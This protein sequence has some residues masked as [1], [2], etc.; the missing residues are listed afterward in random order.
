MEAVMHS[1]DAVAIIGMS[2]R[3]PGAAD[4]I[5]F[6][7]NLCT[8]TESIHFPSIEECVASGV[9]RSEVTKSNYVRAKG[10]L[11]TAGM[12]DA[13]FFRMPPSQ[14]RMMDPQHRLL[15]EC[16]WEAFE[17]AGYNPRECT[18]A[19]GVF[20]GCTTG[21]S[22][23]NRYVKPESQGKL[24]DYQNN[25]HNGTDFLATWVS[26]LLNL[27][28]P[29]MA[30]QTA[31]STGLVAVVTAV[32]SLLSHQ[33]DIA[34]AGAVSVDY[35]L[36]A[37]H[38]H[39][40]G[41]IL[42]SDGRCRPFDSRADGTVRGNGVGTVL[43]KRLED[44]M[45]DHDHIYAI[46]R[47]AAA[48]NDGFLKM[49][50]TAPSI[51]GQAAVITKALE[52]ASLDPDSVG[53]VEAHGTATPLG[54]PIEVA[55]LNKA[56]RSVSTKKSCALGSVK[57]NIGHLDAA[58]GIAGL[59]KAV[60]SVHHGKIPPTVHFQ[61]P[62]PLLRLEEGPFFV[63]TM[64]REWPE[65]RRAGV[66]SFGMGG[67]NAHVV[68]EQA[69]PPPARLGSPADKRVILPLSA[70]TPAALG[71]MSQRLSEHLERHPELPLG[72]VAHTLQ[73]GRETF[74]YRGLLAQH[75]P[76]SAWQL[77]A[78]GDTPVQE[79][80]VMFLFPGQGAQHVGMGRAFYTSEPGFSRALDTCAQILQGEL[81]TD[82][83]DLLY[84]DSAPGQALEQTRL[85]Q[86]VL[87]AVEYALAQLWLSKGI[88]PVAMLGHSLGEY[89]AACLAGVFS[90][91]DALK[92][93]S[94]RGALMQQ[95]AAG[96]MLAVTFPAEEAAARLPKG[97]VVC[98]A[99]SPQSC[100]VGGDAAAVLRLQRQFEIENIACRLLRTSH[101]FHS[102]LM[103]PVL[104]PLA[105]VFNSIS[106]QPPTIPYLSN[107]TGDWVTREQATN[108]DYWLSHVTCPVQFSP[109]L[110][111]AVRD[112]EPI[113]LEVGPGRTLT[114]L[115]AQQ[116]AHPH[117][118]FS[119]LPSDAEGDSTVLQETIHRL[120]FHGAAVSRPVS[121]TSTRRVSLPTYPFQR[122]HFWAGNHACADEP[123]EPTSISELP[124]SSS[125]ASVS[126]SASDAGQALENVIM[127]IWEETLGLS[128]INPHDDFF[129]LGG[130]SLQ[131]V[132]VANRIKSKIS[133][134][135]ST[136][137]L[138]QAPTISA[139]AQIL[140]ASP[141][142]QRSESAL[143]PLKPGTAENPLFL[144]HPVGG[145]VY[146]YRELTSALQTRRAVYGIQADS[147][148][149]ES[150]H[151]RSME[152]MASAYLSEIKSVQPQGPYYLGGASM[153]GIIAYEMARQ[154]HE[155]G[156]MVALLAMLDSPSPGYFPTDLTG[157]E[158]VIRYLLHIDNLDDIQVATDLRRLSPP[159]MAD[160][161]IEN[162]TFAYKYF[163]RK[164]R[165]EVARFLRI[166]DA[167]MGAMSDYR[168]GRYGG[169]ILFL[170]A[171]T[172][173]PYLPRNLD[174]GWHQLID[175]NVTV[176]DVPGN[177]I[178][179]NFT[180][181]VEKSAKI[182]DARLRE[183]PPHGKG[184]T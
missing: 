25:L 121:A 56:Y 32:H 164:S 99:N 145:H 173:D 172:S 73:C 118:A 39:V 101:A 53:Y 41:M 45:A 21:N 139:M 17:D 103:E 64:L 155:Q 176:H 170:R 72:D 75:P 115:A 9:P 57:S 109:A 148:D 18:E 19:A 5:Q 171:R 80:G 181:N 79:R 81:K 163:P 6:W 119:T 50:F 43:L 2:G 36:V 146:L 100:V 15:L 27:R 20:A 85:C 16:A 62:N 151:P 157:P 108:T 179:M 95:T 34:L 14:A 165:D 38:E 87:F 37:G 4:V 124:S 113:L 129:E 69:P 135:A 70:K 174:T 1:A 144:I 88:R 136:H 111:R 150:A 84:H 61:T 10:V 166:F 76:A 183:T 48:N 92:L 29:S 90:L 133:A 35:P 40:E 152:A 98:A 102:P 12:F 60:L 78:K 93:V 55:A 128:P 117:P 59:I 153:G 160:Y 138:I 23:L 22:Y 137:L 149:D 156:E 7:E 161:L 143:V 158:A 182:L 104:A 65:L 47:G 71:E 177:H 86:P 112:M 180:P 127:T 126:P 94:L 33:C 184:R 105:E 24:D 58:A 66:S 68:L 63:N 8:A 26:H 106:L 140:T 147:A 77:M 13:A 134:D 131:A 74:A 122:Q 91:P 167:N 116:L 82:I 107:V 130:T 154:L 46:I 52:M 42:S 31:C 67:T 11:P 141:R 162:G 125:L 97:V 54:D 169:D 123:S 30:V 83:R 142:N 168:P 132:Q 159:A 28:G 3:F 96:A 44:A 175:G 89:V 51:E 110:Q 49:G 178:T 120:W 114:S